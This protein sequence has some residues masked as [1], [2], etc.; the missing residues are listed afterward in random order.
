MRSFQKENLVKNRTK[1]KKG[2]SKKQRKR[3]PGKV[4]QRESAKQ[5]APKKKKKGGTH[6]D[7][8]RKEERQSG[9]CKTRKSGP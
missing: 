8:W 9:G 1:L 5:F 2:W 6:N 4:N 7:P 3:G